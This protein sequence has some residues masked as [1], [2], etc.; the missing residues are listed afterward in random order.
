MRNDAR[1][2]VCQ[3]YS[4]IKD[5]GFAVPGN[6]VSDW[7]LWDSG[8]DPASYARSMRAGS[9]WGGAMEIALC[10]KLRHAFIEIF[11]RRSDHFVRIASFGDSRAA[12]RIRLLYGGRVHYDA[13]ETR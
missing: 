11:E 13:I 12:N 5:P 10:A 9:R 7:V 3:T 8:E 1:N 4:R 2:V 6:P